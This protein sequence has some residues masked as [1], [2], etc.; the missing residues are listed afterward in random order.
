M[1]EPAVRIEPRPP[2]L[3][4]RSRPPIAASARSRFPTHD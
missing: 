3:G 4:A 1:T 2:S